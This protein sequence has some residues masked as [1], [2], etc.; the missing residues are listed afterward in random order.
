MLITNTTL[1]S[2]EIDPEAKLKL[3]DVS[4]KKN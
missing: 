3:F 1:A 4:P 2:E